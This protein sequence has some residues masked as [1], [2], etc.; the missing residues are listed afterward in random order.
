M[1]NGKVYEDIACTYL[2]KNKY[3]I[4]KRNFKIKFGEID[5][6]CKKDDVLIFVEV[7]GGTDKLSDPAY[8]ANRKKLL[9]IS[10]VAQIF[11]QNSNI[12]FS[13]TR[14]DVI[15]VNYDGKINHYKSQRF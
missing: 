3:K 6:I 10:Q 15:S 11:I 1:A 5:I 8:R 4:L 14:I 2:K 13:E 9:K 7:K 12:E